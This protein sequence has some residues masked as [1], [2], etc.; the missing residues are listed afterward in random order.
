VAAGRAL[1]EAELNRLFANG[2]VDFAMSFDPSFIASEVRKGEFDESVRPFLLEG[3]ALVNT[4]YVTIPA[5]AAN[6][7]GAQVVA[8]LLLDPRLQ[9]QKADPA[10]LGIPT[11][12]DL[13]RLDP[14]ERRRFQGSV[15]SP[16]LLD[17]FGDV[18]SE[19]GADQV[20]P[21]EERWTREILR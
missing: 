9:A 5:D 16:Y 6:A 10:R 14:T 8:D 12:L 13:D 15:A 2:E 19:L 21:L 18:K 20:R 1:P 3:G 4:S 7:A 17:D 11:V